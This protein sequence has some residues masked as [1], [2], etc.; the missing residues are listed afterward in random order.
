MGLILVI[1]FFEG[2]GDGC[3]VS[4]FVIRGDPRP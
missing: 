3:G 1:S 2:G 4:S